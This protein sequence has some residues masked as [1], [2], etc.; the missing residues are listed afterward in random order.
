[1]KRVLVLDGGGAKGVIQSQVLKDIERIKG[2]RISDIFDLIVGTS[3]GAILGGIYASGKMDAK[4]IHALLMDTLPK[5]FRK[6]LFRIPKYSRKALDNV[7]SKT[8]GNEF[9]MKQCKSRFICTAVNMVD[10]RTHYFKSWEAVDGELRLNEAIT[11]SY[12]APLFFGSIIDN[13]NKAVW[14]DG[15]TGN[16][17][18]PLLEAVIETV[19]QKWLGDKNQHQSP[20]KVH[21]LSIGTGH[22][23]FSMSFK[24]ARRARTIRQVLFFLDPAEGGLARNQSTVS[25]VQ[26]IKSL[27]TIMKELS[28]QRLNP[29]IS[30]RLDRMDGV[31]YLETYQNIGESLSDGIDHSK[32]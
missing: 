18:C 4:Y 10:G 23:D 11:R 3:V 17:N 19:R 27:S 31:R 30:K 14:L 32:L 22:V 24:R 26:K 12:A 15:G 6:R 21:I 16:A 1:M 13:K 7:L 28:F 5:V 2:R 8:I 9:R 20:E 25:R 29:E